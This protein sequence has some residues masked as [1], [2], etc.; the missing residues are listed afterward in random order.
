[1]RRGAEAREDELVAVTLAWG[2]PYWRVWQAWLCVKVL[3]EVQ[4]SG[5]LAPFAWP[6]LERALGYRAGDLRDAA[7][8]RDEIVITD[9]LD[10]VALAGRCGAKRSA[11]HRARKRGWI[12]LGMADAWCDAAGL[13]PI[14][15][16]G[17]WYVAV[18]AVL[19][20][21]RLVALEPLPDMAVAS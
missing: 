15:V 3:R 13:A 18:S 7:Y 14:E 19:T 21:G 11:I 16:W 1:M 8:Q 5:P 2:L 17:D 9:G 10:N 20:W 4:P 6:P 12:T